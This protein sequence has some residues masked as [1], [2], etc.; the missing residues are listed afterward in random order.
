MEQ[1]FL[2]QLLED[3]IFHRIGQLVYVAYVQRTIPTYILFG[4]SMILL[5]MYAYIDTCIKMTIYKNFLFFLALSYNFI[6]FE[7]LL[8]YF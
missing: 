3:I 1:L 4:I 2:G 5:D 8:L 7:N 6:L